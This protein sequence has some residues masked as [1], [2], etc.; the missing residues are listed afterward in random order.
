MRSSGSG[1]QEHPIVE[2]QEVKKRKRTNSAKDMQDC[3][4]EDVEVESDEEDE[5]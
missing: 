1:K 2:E 4:E 3:D 5:E